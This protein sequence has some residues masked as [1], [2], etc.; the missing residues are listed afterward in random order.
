MIILDLPS[1][2][3]IN[4][5]SGVFGRIHSVVFESDSVNEFMK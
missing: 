4:F 2:Q 3:S 1:L 5:D